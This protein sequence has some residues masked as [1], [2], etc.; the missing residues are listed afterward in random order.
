MAAKKQVEKKGKVSIK[1]DKPTRKLRPYNKFRTWCM[2]RGLSQIAIS[3]ATNNSRG[4]VNNMWHI[5]NCND[6]T[7]LLLEYVFNDPKKFTNTA[8]VTE[9]ELRKMITTFV[10]K[11]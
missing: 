4:S 6:S 5:G 11:K 8:G 9:A 7:I 10:V 3:D 1:Q 2:E